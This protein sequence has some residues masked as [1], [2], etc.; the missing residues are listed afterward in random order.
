MIV[1]DVAQDA[2]WAPLLGLA[3][4]FGIAACWSFLLKGPGGRVLGTF[5]LY[6][7]KPCLPDQAALDE[8]R[9][10]VNIASLMIDRHIASATRE[11]EQRAREAA[12]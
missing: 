10:F 4:E 11:N 5:A 3:R 1:G 7:R 12:R 9:Y 6:H 2:A 8:V